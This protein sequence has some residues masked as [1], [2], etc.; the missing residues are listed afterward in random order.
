[1][2]EYDPEAVEAALTATQAAV[3]QMWVRIAA[4]IEREAASAPP[5]ADRELALEWAARLRRRLRPRAVR[6]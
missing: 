3:A 6:R 2:G 4:A 1:M 5:G